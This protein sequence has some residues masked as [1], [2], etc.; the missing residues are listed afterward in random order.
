MHT[1]WNQANAWLDNKHG[2][3]TQDPFK[4]LAFLGDDKRHRGELKKMHEIYVKSKP[5]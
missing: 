1:I 4:L 2:E 3:Q 5:S